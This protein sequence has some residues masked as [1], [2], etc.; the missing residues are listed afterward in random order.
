M[1]KAQNG[2]TLNDATTAQGWT[3]RTPE[4]II[5][6]LL[7]FPYFQTVAPGLLLEALEQATESRKEYDNINDLAEHLAAYYI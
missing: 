3:I 1:Y 7:S 5:N 2:F 4:D 6:A